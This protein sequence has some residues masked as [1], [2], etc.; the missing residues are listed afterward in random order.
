M[1]IQCNLNEKLTN[2]APATVENEPQLFDGLFQPGTVF[3]EFTL[4]APNL[5]LTTALQPI[6]GLS[7]LV[8]YKGTSTLTF[9][10]PVQFPRS[11]PLPLA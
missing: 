4:E 5:L 10:L 11:R 6:D 3:F 2:E 8:W 7:G 1:S 9:S